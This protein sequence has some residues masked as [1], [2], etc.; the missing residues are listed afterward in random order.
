MWAIDLE[1]NGAG[2]VGTLDREEAARMAP[3]APALDRARLGAR[4]AGA[5]AIL[6]AYLRR[7]RGGRVGASRRPRG[8][9]RRARSACRA[10]AASPCSRSQ[11]RRRRAST[12]SAAGRRGLRADS[13]RVL[14]A[15]RGGPA[16]RLAAARSAAFLR[17]SDSQEAV[18]GVRGG[19]CRRAGRVGRGAGAARRLAPRGRAARRRPRRLVRVENLP[20]PGHVAALATAGA[21]Q[22]R[23]L[24]PPP[25]VA[26]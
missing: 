2:H 23:W 13:G 21:R 10:P 19:P 8:W 20:V 14:H 12:S 15:R 22:P 18:Q 1:R 4:T 11:R 17:L 16:A 24:R 9:R 6:G 7:R 25:E 26:R 3:A 5:R